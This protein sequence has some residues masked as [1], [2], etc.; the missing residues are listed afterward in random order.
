MNQYYVSYRYIDQR[1]N[2]RH[3][4]AIFESAY[5]LTWELVIEFTRERAVAELGEEFVILYITKLEYLDGMPGR[6]P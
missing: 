6:R 3:S 4:W 5:G 2:E 1:G